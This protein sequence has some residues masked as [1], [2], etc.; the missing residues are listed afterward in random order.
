MFA[1][2]LGNLEAEECLTMLKTLPLS[3]LDVNTGTFLS[4]NEKTFFVPL[5]IGKWVGR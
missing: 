3:N 4:E 2:A 1:E 5:H